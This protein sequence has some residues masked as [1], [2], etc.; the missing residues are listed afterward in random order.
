M[1]A[2]A[3]RTS[4]PQRGRPTAGD[5]RNRARAVGHCAHW[6]PRWLRRN[7]LCIDTAACAADGHLTVAE[8]QSGQPELHFFS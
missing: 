5:S 8:I 1:A 4:G 7:V 6:E 3:H 2:T